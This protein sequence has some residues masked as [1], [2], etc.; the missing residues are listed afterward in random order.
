[1]AAESQFTANTGMVTISTANANLDGT[2]ALGTVLTGASKGT[3]VK[4]VVI[5]AKG[6][7]TAEGMVRLFVSDGTA[8]LIA[9]VEIPVVTQSAKD[10]CFEK[11]I[12]L[13]LDLKAGDILYASTEKADTFN[14]IAEGLDWSYLTAVRE[15]STNYTANTGN[16]L[17]STSNS[18]LD[19]TGTVAT[20]LTAGATADGYKG[21]CIKTILIKGTGSTTADGMVRLFIQDTNSNIKLLTEI[22]VPIVTQTASLRSFVHQIDFG[23]GLDSSY[24]GFNLAPGY[25]I[26]ASTQLANSFIVTAEGLDRS[27]PASGLKIVLNKNFSPVS[28]TSTQTEELLQSYQVNSGVIKVGDLLEVIV[29]TLYTNNANNKTIRVYVNSS[30]T[31]TAATLLATR[32][33]ASVASDDLQRFFPVISD[34]AIECYGA[35]A[36]SISSS[37]AQ[38]TGVSANVTVPSLKAGFWILISLQKASSADSDTIRWSMVRYSRQ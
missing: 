37:Y 15:A 8:R 31:L 12:E 33:S 21:T 9:E 22:P 14:I 1:M 18:N 38:T 5:K 23:G 29:S 10:A 30:N 34:T 35:A 32:T 16:A 20:V 26:I 3:K 36:T 2:G 24:D 28:G 6:S 11:Y 13:D 7:T 4:S 17:I 27:Y 19:G 25:S